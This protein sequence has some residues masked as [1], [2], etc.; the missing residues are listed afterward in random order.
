M[1]LQKDICMQIAAARPEFLN[2][3]SVPAERV[4]KEKRNFKSS[5]N[6]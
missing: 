4:E 2:E 3:A 1:K 6:E 5:N